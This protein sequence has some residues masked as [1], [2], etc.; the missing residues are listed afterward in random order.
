MIKQLLFINCQENEV[1]TMVI[2]VF[3]K[4][5]SP[6]LFLFVTCFVQV[7]ELSDSNL[8]WQVYHVKSSKIQP[9]Y[10]FQQA[11]LTE[12][13]F[14]RYFFSG[15]PRLH[16]QG[17]QKFLRGLMPLLHLTKTWQLPIKIIYISNGNKTKMAKKQQISTEVSSA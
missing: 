4:K 7:S 16:S 12:T 2:N 13:S 3:P 14:F 9:H 8:R 10:H 1:D 5:R 6:L 15:L 17:I 11:A